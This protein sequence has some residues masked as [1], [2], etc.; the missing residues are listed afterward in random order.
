MDD[1]F[2]KFRNFQ[3]FAENLRPL[4][5]ETWAFWWEGPVNVRILLTKTRIL[6]L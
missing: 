3:L 4:N 1:I 6:G 2:H 5:V